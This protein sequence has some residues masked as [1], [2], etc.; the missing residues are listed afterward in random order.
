MSGL[1]RTIQNIGKRLKGKAP[2]RM[3]RKTSQSRISGI[4]KPRIQQM[5]GYQV[6][7]LMQNGWLGQFVNNNGQIAVKDIIDNMDD[8]SQ[9]EYNLIHRAMSNLTQRNGQ[10][11]HLNYDQLRQEVQNLIPK[12]NRVPQ[13]DYEDYGL[14]RLGYNTRS[15]AEDELP[16]LPNVITLGQPV[17]FIPSGTKADKIQL[18]TF[19]FESPGIV[20]N[21]KHYSGQ[22]IGH[23]RTYTTAEEPDILHVME[24]QSDWAQN[25]NRNSMGSNVNFSAAQDQEAWNAAIQMYK[26]QKTDAVGDVINDQWLIDMGHSLGVSD[27]EINQILGKI[28]STIEKHL[29][30]NY[31]SRQIQE[32]L[33]YAAENGQTKMRFPTRETAAKIEGYSKIKTETQ[34]AKDIYNQYENEIQNVIQQH[35]EWKIRKNL[36]SES[37]LSD[38]LSKSIFYGY[39]TRNLEGKKVLKLIEDKYKPLYDKATESQYSPQ[40]ETILKKYNAFPEQFQS[41]FSDG[42]VRTVTDSKNNTWFE[43]DV[44]KGMLLRELQFRNGGR[45]PKGQFGWISK[46]F[47]N[48][49]LIRRMPV[50]KVINGKT[51]LIL[52]ENAV[53]NFTTTRTFDPHQHYKARVIGY[54]PAIVVDSEAIKQWKPISLQP[55]DSFFINDV[56]NSTV[57]PSQITVISGIPEE[58]E[59]AKQNGFNVFTTDNLQQIASN[60]QKPESQDFLSKFLP[61]GRSITYAMDYKHALDDAIAQQFPTNIFN[62]IG[63]K[64]RH[65]KVKIGLDKLAALKGKVKFDSTPSNEA[66]FF[67]E[68]GYEKGHQKGEDAKQKVIDYYNNK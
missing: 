58:L 67:K 31:L 15:I 25:Y 50:P 20:G 43:V 41:L 11:T 35:P 65:P 13:T 10:N 16:G 18:N 33:R 19:S 59:Q 52:G 17:N 56:L 4:V 66:R 55:M 36:F 45:I 64:L 26:T 57:N 1:L 51:Q 12:Y 7:A 32:N 23:A 53:G 6:P 42:K 37:E 60:A 8:L 22:P 40:H 34:E 3:Q 21:T 2:N 27:V 47:K 28:N 61:G 49:N 63:M 46:I 54:A 48:P 68:L 38:D 5:P 30:K 39:K 9:I 29:I 14:D 24:S 62:Y 44:P